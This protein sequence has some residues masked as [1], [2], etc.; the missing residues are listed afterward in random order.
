MRRAL[1]CDTFLTSVN[2]LSE[3][4]VL[5]NVDGMGNR[6]AAMLFGPKS[7]VV[8]AGMN[9][10]CRTE[11]EAETRARTYAGP[12]NAA[13][14]SLAKTPCGSTGVCGDCKSDECICSYT[15][16]VRMSKVPGRIK[17]ILVGEPLGF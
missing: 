17:V 14:F 6:V 13:R 1:T 9:K 15:V 10:V 5:V 8:V 11:A 4:G 3:D 2:G 7:V 16:K 12:L